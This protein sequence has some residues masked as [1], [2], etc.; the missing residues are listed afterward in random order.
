MLGYRHSQPQIPLISG[1][2]PSHEDRELDQ[3][4]AELNFPDFGQGFAALTR[5]LP[6]AG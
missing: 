5:G 4:G 6:S 2:L 1:R 3:A